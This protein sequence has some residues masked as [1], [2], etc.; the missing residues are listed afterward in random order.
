MLI[1]YQGDDGPEGAKIMKARP[2]E[3]LNELLL[4]EVFERLGNVQGFISCVGRGKV[5]SP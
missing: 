1:I 3:Q 5:G 2:R 4:S